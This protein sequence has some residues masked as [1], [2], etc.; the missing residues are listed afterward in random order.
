[1]ADGH[2]KKKPI[3]FVRKKH[4]DLIGKTPDEQLKAL[5]AIPD[6]LCGHR[7][8]NCTHQAGGCGHKYKKGDK[9][10]VCPECGQDRRCNSPKVKDATACRMHGGSPNR[11]MDPA[12]RY[13]A[14]L[15]ILDIY[16]ERLA[17]PDLLNMAQEIAA[18]Q[19]RNFQLFEMI[20]ANDPS[21]ALQQLLEGL[22]MIDLGLTQTNFFKIR[23][24]Y[25]L[26]MESL[27]PIVLQAQG[28]IEL[29]NNFD[30][31][32]KMTDKQRDW[33]MQ[34]RDMMPAAHVIETII[35]VFREASKYI[36]DKNDKRQFG[37][38]I[39]MI[40]PPSDD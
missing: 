27:D 10:W 13:A 5:P 11:K 35:Y 33:L 15:A 34:D 37:N 1:M 8:K 9:S 4:P 36:R 39:K 21:L 18:I 17:D 26:C 19:A 29:R 2:K 31:Q 25:Q 32:T 6:T 7:N 28:W 14:P 23:D 12:R 22:R 20:D 38:S 40:I 30:L 16:N 3:Q 24:G